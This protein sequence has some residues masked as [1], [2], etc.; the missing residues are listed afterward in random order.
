MSQ[1]IHSDLLIILA[2]LAVMTIVSL[3]LA[4]VALN[5]N[6]RLRRQVRRWRGTHTAADLDK[7]S[8]D[9]VD[10]VE[11]LRT[12]IAD[13]QRTKLGAIHAELQTIHRILR[14]KVTT[15]SVDR[16]NAFDDQGSDLSFSVA[17]LDDEQNGVV[18]SSIYGRQESRTYAKPV[19][20]GVSR[21]PL[22]D[23][24]TSVISQVASTSE[25]EEPKERGLHR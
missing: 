1:L 24:E 16:Y 19:Q 14:H 5:S 2:M 21:Y 7:V 11:E 12:A 17:F 9:T 15:P 13:L 18:M 22:T 3:I 23:E 10:E 20:R 6:A 8:G 25:P 4:I